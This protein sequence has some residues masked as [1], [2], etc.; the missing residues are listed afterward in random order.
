MKIFMEPLRTVILRNFQY[1]LKLL[2][3][4]KKYLCVINVEDIYANI[5][6]KYFLE[7]AT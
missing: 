1:W 2:V 7:K 3:P 5:L 4:Y 6:D